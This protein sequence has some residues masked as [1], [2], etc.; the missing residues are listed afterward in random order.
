MRTHV[1]GA[2]LLPGRLL[3]VDGAEVR[4]VMGLKLVDGEQVRVLQEGHLV[5]LDAQV[6]IALDLAV[7]LLSD[8]GLHAL[9]ASSNLGCA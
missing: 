6:C 1:W 7:A 5:V 2:I 9:C 4:P 8:L 3:H